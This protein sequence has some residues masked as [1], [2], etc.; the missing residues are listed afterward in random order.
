MS[1]QVSTPPL[2]SPVALMVGRFGFTELSLN[3]AVVR[4]AQLLSHGAVTSGFTG[5]VTDGAALFVDPAL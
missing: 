1:Q 5:I 4:L 2:G 3:L